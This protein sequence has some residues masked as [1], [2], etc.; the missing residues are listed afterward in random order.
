MQK[1]ACLH[2]WCC[3]HQPCPGSCADMQQLIA[4]SAPTHFLHPHA[5]A[6][7]PPRPFETCPGWSLPWCAGGQGGQGSAMRRGCGIGGGQGRAS[8]P[9]T[10]PSCTND[11]AR[12]HACFSRSTTRRLTLWHPHKVPPL[13]GAGR[14][15]GHRHYS[16]IMC[17]VQGTFTQV[18]WRACGQQAE[19]LAHVL[20]SAAGHVC[21][22]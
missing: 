5:A 21:T 17:N 4:P 7:W 20:T 13:V 8:A 6:L 15:D 9:V 16:V 3:P 18:W 2:A 19:G 11:A 22:A 10:A 1:A 14:L 12:M